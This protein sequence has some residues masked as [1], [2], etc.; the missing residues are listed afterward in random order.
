MLRGKIRLLKSAFKV[1]N[2]AAFRKTIENVRLRRKIELVFDKIGEKL[3]A[4]LQFK[5]FR[6]FNDEMIFIDWLR[7]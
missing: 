6:V 3:L 1:M 5:Q 4:K 2:N 7:T